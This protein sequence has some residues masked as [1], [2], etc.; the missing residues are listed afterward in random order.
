MRPAQQEAEPLLLV[1]EIQLAHTAVHRVLADE[2]DEASLAYIAGPPGTGKS[3]LVDHFTAA[4]TGKNGKCITASVFAGELAEAS[5]ER[6]LPEFQEQ[7]RGLDLFVCEDVQALSGRRETQR[8]LLAVL[9]CVLGRGGA[10]VIT[11]TRLP[12]RLGRFDPR[13]VSRFRGG[14][15]A[16]IRRP[17]IASRQKLLEHFADRHGL[18]ISMEK[19]QVLAKKILDSPRELLA[20]IRQLEALARINNTPVDDCLV[21]QLVTEPGGMGHQTLSTITRTV[22]RL[23]GVSAR[24]LRQR[25]RKREVVLPRH[26]AMYLARKLTDHTCQ[27]VATYFGC[28]NHTAVLHACRRIRLLLPEDPLLRRRLHAIEAELAGREDTSRV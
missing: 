8:Q 2:T 24:C 20:G 26:C 3:H 27:H 4:A 21:Q 14:V 22:A 5:D 18:E 28:R 6:L 7:Y 1:P 16:S 23:F 13:L 17:S 10:V 12:G 19:L 9:D 25:S 11:A 15:V